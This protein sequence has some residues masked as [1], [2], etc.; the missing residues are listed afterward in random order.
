[1]P[2]IVLLM[3]APH[4]LQKKYVISGKFT[5]FREIFYGTFFRRLKLPV[6][7][8]SEKSLEQFCG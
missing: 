8:I 5:A 6:L 7:E 3:N 2:Q 1:M 4:K